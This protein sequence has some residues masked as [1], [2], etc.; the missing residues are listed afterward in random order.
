MSA[1][2]QECFPPHLLNSTI[3]EK[4]KYFADYAV[5][6]TVLSR[7]HDRLLPSILYP[8]GKQLVFVIGPPAAGKSFLRGW[9]ENGIR[10]EWRA[11]QKTDPG[12]IPV[13]SIEIPSRD[14][15]KTTPKDIY[16][17]ILRALEEPLIA[18]KIVYG[19]VAMNRN[20]DGFV[21]F[22]PKATVNR[23]RYATEQA[24]KYRRPYALL[25]DEAQ[26]LFNFAGLTMPEIMDWIKS[27]ANM[28]GVTIVLFGTYEMIDMLDL[29]DQLMRRSLVLHLR[30][31]GTTHDDQIKYASTINAFQKNMP[32]PKEPDLLKYREYLY[33]RTAGCIGNLYDWLSA[34]YNR[35]LRNNAKTVTLNDLKLTT[36][37][38]AKRAQDMSENM[39]KDEVKL[40][41]LV[42][43]E[44]V[45]LNKARKSSAA[46]RSQDKSKSIKSN[47]ST[48]NKPKSKRRL[49]VGERKP[50]RDEIGGRA[51]NVN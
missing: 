2:I 32:L 20:A 21:I 50:G 1:K 26:H 3:H 42:G 27:I 19:D 24:L 13:V 44:D 34:A 51:K 40:I 28:T 8:Y 37:L 46:K 17:R 11:Q 23:L 45:V 43:E 49:P 6:H 16:T 39:I 38:S 36:P 25:L 29:S 12:R 7:V 5:I 15:N 31:Y 10:E 4:S 48:N 35:A 47:E 41:E 22:D 9:I 18:N 33:E 30:R 14:S